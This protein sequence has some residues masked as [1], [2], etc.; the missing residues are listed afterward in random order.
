MRGP[1]EEYLQEI[2]DGLEEAGFFD[3]S[4]V[5]KGTLIKQFLKVMDHNLDTKGDFHLSESDI[6]EAYDNAVSEE[7]DE[8]LQNA[9]QDGIL[10]IAG[11]DDEGQ[12]IY[13]LSDQ[14]KEIAKG[15]D[16]QTMIVTA[17]FERFG[18]FD[19]HCLN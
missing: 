5:S 11:V 19:P 13:Q 2:V 7:V 12:L 9:M 6:T 3:L 17:K 16:N 1:V 18:N 4:F 14:G 15:F 8:F 10:D